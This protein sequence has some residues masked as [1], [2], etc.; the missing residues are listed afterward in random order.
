MEEFLEN[1]ILFLCMKTF[2]INRHISKTA[3]LQKNV[4]NFVILLR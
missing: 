1:I 2:E 4:N 3:F